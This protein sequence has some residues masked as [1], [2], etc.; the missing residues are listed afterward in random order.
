MQ[1]CV[2]LDPFRRE[3]APPSSLGLMGGLHSLSSVAKTLFPLSHLQ[4]LAA[5]EM[6]FWLLLRNGMVQM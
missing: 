5:V 4:E 2:L 3:Q 1:L 6:K